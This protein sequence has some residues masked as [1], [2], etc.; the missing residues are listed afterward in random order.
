MATLSVFFGIIVRMYMEQGGKHNL[1]HIHADYQD[2]S[3]VIDLDGEIIGGNFPIGKQKLLVAWIEIHKDD[4]LA[5]WKLLSDGNQFFKI[6][7]L[8]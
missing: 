8:K 6:E 5:N 2:F 4:L 3:I 1:P 7:P